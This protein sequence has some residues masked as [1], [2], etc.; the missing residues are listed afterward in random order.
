MREPL[1]AG[2]W[3]MNLTNPEAVALVRELLAAPVT[4]KGCEVVVCPPFTALAEVGLVLSG[5]AIRLGAQ[6]LHWEDSGAFT[7]EVSAA[8]LRS[9][10]C[11]HVIVGHS[12]RRHKFSEDD[13]G[14]GRKT[15]AALEGGLIPIVCVGETLGER[16]RGITEQ[17][18]KRQLEAVLDNLG[19]APSSPWIVAYEPVWAIGT[20]QTATPAQAQEVHAFARSLLADR[21]GQAGEETRILYGGSVTAENAADLM[22]RPDVDGALVGGASLK[23]PSFTAIVT[24]A[25]A[26]GAAR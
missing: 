13:A 15:R 25:G 26:A 7:G 14:V 11:T 2:N 20:G 23:A 17:V 6:N 5:T 9:V 10:S 24:A 16:E 19:A 8:Q 4:G 21:W 12:E 22:S 18:V 1:V 3:K